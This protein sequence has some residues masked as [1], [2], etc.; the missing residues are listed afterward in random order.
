MRRRS[1]ISCYVRRF[2][3]GLHLQCGVTMLEV[4]IAILIFSFGLL[5]IAG[6]QL[7][8]LRYQKEAWA[9][10]SAAAMAADIAERMRGN[11]QGAKNGSYGLS[12]SYTALRTAPPVA[13]G[14]NARTGICTAA[15]IA[16][17]DISD[18]FGQIEQELPAGAGTLGGSINNGFTVR[19]MWMDKDAV[20]AQGD[21]VRAP[22]CAAS[23]VTQ[24]C[25]PAATPAGVRCVNTVFIP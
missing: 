12:G 21:L 25:C 19:V 16:Q 11:L 17:N 7:A 6:L 1:P 18:W 15:Q 23:A 13:S 14:C 4:L 24:N 3:P 20:D 9:R 8:A 2:S 22:Q 5:A 10:S